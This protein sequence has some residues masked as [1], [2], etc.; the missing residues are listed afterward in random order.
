MRRI[1]FSLLRVGSCGVYIE[2]LEALLIWG[3]VS[4]A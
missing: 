4:S 1:T 2:D 3:S